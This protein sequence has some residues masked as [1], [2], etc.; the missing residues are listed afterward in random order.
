[1]AEKKRFYWIKL[2]ENFFNI[3]TIDWLISQK[4]GCEY[5]V[6]Y[7]KLCLLS[8]NKNGELSMTVGE[9][10]IPYDEAKIARETKFEI[11]TVIVALELFKRIG[12]IYEQED[13][14]LKIPY[15][16][17]MVGSETSSAKRVREHRQRKAL[18]CNTECNST[19]T[20]EIENRDKRLDIRYIEK[21]SEEKR[22][23]YEHIKDMYN[24]IC[25]SFPRL[26]VLSDKRKQAIK[27]RL[28]TYSIEQIKTLFEKAEA[29]DFLKG[30]NSR[31]WQAN[32]DWLMKDS[33]FAKV[34]DGNYDNKGTSQKP[35]ENDDADFLEK[36]SV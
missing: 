9:M 21:D 11:D 1:M 15:V 16:E 8:A 23:N 17:E 31:D 5:I 35:A 34:L 12:L 13:G 10:I 33:N 6:L 20:Q 3:E 36:W 7:Q 2:K 32:F 19:V 27:A 22:I 25:I 29:S 14:I 28:K 26:T 24:D 30:S 18:Q 4:N